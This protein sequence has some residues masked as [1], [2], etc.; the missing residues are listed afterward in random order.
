MAD[1]CSIEQELSTVG[2]SGGSVRPSMT[3]E[4]K[5]RQKPP[6]GRSQSVK[7]SGGSG[8]SS[9]GSG[10]SSSSSSTRVSPASTIRPAN[11][12]LDDI[13]AQLERA[14]KSMDEAAR[15]STASFTSTASAPFSSSSSGMRRPTHQH[16]RRTGSVGTVIEH[17]VRS[18]VHSSRSS[19]NSTSASSVDSLEMDKLRAPG[20]DGVN[21]AAQQSS[22]VTTRGYGYNNHT[23]HTQ[24][25]SVALILM[26]TFIFITIST[27]LNI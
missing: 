16:H 8:G 25:K 26:C 17:D 5:V 27:Y 13:T 3:G 24:R 12:S 9:G 1:L 21:S 6:A 15:L 10:G 7:H 4:A 14:S 22:E 23:K 20:E 2:K 18:I 19:I 11:F